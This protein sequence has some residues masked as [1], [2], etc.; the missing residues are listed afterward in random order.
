MLDVSRDILPLTDFKRRTAE[1]IGRLKET[2]RPLVLTVNGKPEI[3]VLD[4]CGYQALQER[5]RGLERRR[6]G[7]A[8]HAR[9]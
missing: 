1:F 8:V 3:V 7:D 5:L 2:G 6:R 9:D 4:A